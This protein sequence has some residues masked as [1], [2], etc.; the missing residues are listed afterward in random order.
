MKQPYMDE[1]VLLW[2]Y[3]T[4]AAIDTFNGDITQEVCAE[5]AEYFR[6]KLETIINN[7]KSKVQQAD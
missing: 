1:A 7:E 4:E 3:V 5:R 6:A 2:N